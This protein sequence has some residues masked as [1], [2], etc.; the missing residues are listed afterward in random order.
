LSRKISLPAVDR[1][2]DIYYVEQ[3]SILERGTTI[4]KE[5]KGIPRQDASDSI[6]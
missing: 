1:Y 3:N 5:N 4:K 6:S 2:R